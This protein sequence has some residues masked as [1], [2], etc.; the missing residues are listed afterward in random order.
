MLKFIIDKKSDYNNHWNYCIENDIP[1]VSIIPARKFAQ[2]EFDVLSML[3]FYE[4]SKYPTD[5]LIT[6]YKSYSEFFNLPINKFNC[7]GGS[8]NLIFT[9][10]KEH[11]EIFALQLFDYLDVFVKKNRKEITQV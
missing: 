3:D 4:L 11:S 9:L 7:S 8:K 10:Y 5:F 2:V 6:L 1:F